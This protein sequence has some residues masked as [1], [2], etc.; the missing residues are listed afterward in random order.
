MASLTLLERACRIVNLRDDSIPETAI[1]AVAHLDDT[2]QRMVKY[3]VLGDL[4]LMTAFGL[5]DAV[6]EDIAF[7]MKAE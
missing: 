3:R 7:A 4:D 1:V 5:V 6:R 2:G